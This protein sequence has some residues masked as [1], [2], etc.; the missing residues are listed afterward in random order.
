M[1]YQHDLPPGWGL[2]GSWPQAF[3]AGRGE[4]TPWGSAS[5]YLR[6]RPSAA[7]AAADT[8]RTGTIIQGFNADGYR[9]RRLRYSAVV[10]AEG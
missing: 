3:D 10:R 7:S 1:S 2:S 9:G 8:V 6:S 5:V 4:P